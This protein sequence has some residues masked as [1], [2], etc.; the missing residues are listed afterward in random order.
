MLHKSRGRL[1]V[2]P[3]SSAA[4]H[5]GVTSLGVHVKAVGFQKKKQASQ[6]TA[7]VVAG[8]IRFGGGLGERVDGGDVS[9]LAGPG[10]VCEWR[11]EECDKTP[12]RVLL[13]I[14]QVRE[15]WINGRDVG[16]CS[17]MTAGGFQVIVRPSLD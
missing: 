5:P 1:N 17:L 14:D 9:E 6:Q 10:E 15:R 12:G 16:D 13:M 11:R 7:L 2:C 8:M 3:D 4:D